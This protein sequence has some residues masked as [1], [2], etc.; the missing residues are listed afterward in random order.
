MPSNQVAQIESSMSIVRTEKGLR[1]RVNQPVVAT[2]HNP[3]LGIMPQVVDTRTAWTGRGQTRPVDQ[4]MEPVMDVVVEQRLATSREEQARGV[5][6]G[7]KAI[8]RSGIA[9]EGLHGRGVKRELTGLAE[10]CLADHQQGSVV[11]EVTAV[12]P[13]G[14]AH[15]HA[16]DGEQAEEGPVGPGAEAVP[17]SARRLEEPLDV[18]LGVDVG[19]WAPGYVADQMMRRDF[20]P[21]IKG[22]SVQ[23]KLADEA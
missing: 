8:A 3:A 4:T 10:L 23:S 22:L 2:R 20:G 1:E 11:V 18:L 7:D 16:G 13:Y 6:E 15:A 17:L 9:A 19:R 12:K 5:L 21:G 14:L